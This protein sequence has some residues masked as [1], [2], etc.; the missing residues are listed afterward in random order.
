MCLNT[1]A[2]ARM[3]EALG[4]AQHCGPPSYTP[5]KDHMRQDSP[6]WVISRRHLMMCLGFC[7]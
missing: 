6:G 5:L 7:Q 4:S 1:A 3:R 2:L